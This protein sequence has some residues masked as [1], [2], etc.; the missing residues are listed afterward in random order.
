MKFANVEKWDKKESLDG[1]L[2]FA[3]RLDEMLFHYTNHLYK[4]PVLNTRL[5]IQEYINTAELVKK[6]VINENHLKHI[7]DEFVYSFESDPVIKT[8]LDEEFAKEILHKVK[9]STKE[10]LEEIMLYLLLKLNDY[11]DWCKGMILEQMER[12]REKKKI[13]N[14]LRCFVPG[15]IGE[16]YSHEYIYHYNRKIFFEQSVDS[17]DSLKLFLDRFDFNTRKYTVYV[18][19]A[20]EASPFYEVL[21]TR[22]GAETAKY[23][24]YADLRYDN[25]TYDIIKL[26][27]NELDANKAAQA[28]YD[29]LSLFFRYYNFLVESK[30]QWLSN[31]CKVA[32]GSGEVSFVSLKQEGFNYSRRLALSDMTENVITL[33]IGNEETS[34]LTIDKAIEM[35]NMAISETNLSNGFLNLWSIF[36]ILFVNEQTE[37]K[38]NEIEKKMVPILEKEYIN[39]LIYELYKYIDEN[40]SGKSIEEF[41]KKYN[42]TEKG[43]FH[44]LV[45][46]KENADKRQEFYKI[47][48]DYPVIRSRMSAYH[49]M[50]C[51]KESIVKDLDRFSQR[52]KWH[53]KRLYRTRNALIHSGENI[54]NLK[55][56]GEHLHSYV[57][58]CLNTIISTLIID[59]YLCT[60][61]NVITE[62]QFEKAIHS[63]LLEQKGD[64]EDD[65]IPKIFT[66]H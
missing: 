45:I 10:N 26:S 13:E 6:G 37:S 34:F 41:R 12:P 25:E 63:K 65:D 14:L 40:V 1:M 24:E 5:L 29:R 8:C 27:V 21:N 3:Q 47:L 43:W 48:S 23:E 64:V 66:V 33:L 9:A 35:H 52:I 38:I 62:I 44:K 58:G 54:N 18:A 49:E 16:G 36:E 55:V 46:L 60:I 59:D 4:V 22:V 2:Y 28:A 30:E 32:N 56:L 11:N 19:I 17:L 57:D 50:L 20:K 31:L 42:L 53:L 39:N 61:N 51:K 15:L 7:L